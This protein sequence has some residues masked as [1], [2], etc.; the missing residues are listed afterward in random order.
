MKNH[1]RHFRLRRL[2]SQAELAEKVGVTQAAIAQ[3]ETGK[4]KPVSDKLI[5]LS[6]ALEVSIEELLGVK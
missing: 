6:E 5:K 3:W 1:I 2:L 4:T